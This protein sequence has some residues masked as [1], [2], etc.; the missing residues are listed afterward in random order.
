MVA[1]LANAVCQQVAFNDVTPTHRIVKVEA[2]TRVVEV[3]IALEVRSAG[4]RLE[5]HTR[6]FLPETKHRKAVNWRDNSF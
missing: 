1:R 2:R 4:H 3:H 6:L 5:P